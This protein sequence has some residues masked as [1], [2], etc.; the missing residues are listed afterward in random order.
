MRVCIFIFPHSILI[1]PHTPQPYMPHYDHATQAILWKQLHQHSNLSHLTLEETQ[2]KSRLTSAF[3]KRVSTSILVIGPTGCGKRELVEKVLLSYTTEGVR[4]D[5]TVSIARINGLV[6]VTDNQ[7][8][9]SMAD[10]LLLRPSTFDRNINI[11][12]EDIENHFRVGTSPLDFPSLCLPLSLLIFPSISHACPSLSFLFLP[13][14]ASAHLPCSQLLTLTPP[15]PPPHPPTHP[16]THHPQQ[17]R[18][19]SQPAVIIVEEIQEFLRRDKQVL[20]YTLL[21][22]MHKEDL[23]F[24]VSY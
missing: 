21:D 10:Q 20:I 12:H 17:C 3:D 7:A 24:V 2:I 8:V 5:Q 22:L 14:I 6:H 16:P 19:N 13:F 18:R 9:M 15:S 23:L 11:A 1:I 4:A